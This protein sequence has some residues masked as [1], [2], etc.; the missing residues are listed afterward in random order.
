MIISKDG[1]KD[2]L[3]KAGYSYSDIGQFCNELI[4]D[5][6]IKRQDS[7][8]VLTSEGIS[9]INKYLESEKSKGF[10]KYVIPFDNYRKVKLSL[11]DI[12]IP[13]HL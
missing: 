7:Y 3:I 2:T 13:N 12:Y 8:F 11:D 4:E 6:L 1:D 10:S 9:L 5:R